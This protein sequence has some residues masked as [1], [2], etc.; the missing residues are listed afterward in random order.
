MRKNHLF[1]MLPVLMALGLASCNNN[2]FRI[3]GN[4]TNAEDSVLYFENVGIEG[5]STLDSV[6]LSPDGAFTFRADAPE[7]P[8]F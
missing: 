3:E 4:I 8:E 2:Q 5:I 1:L 6:R 7:A